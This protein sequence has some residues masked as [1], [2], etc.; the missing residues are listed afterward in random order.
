MNLRYAS[1][2]GL[3][4]A[5]AGIAILFY[6]QSL[7][8]TQIDPIMIQVFAVALMVWARLTFGM[9]S[10]HAAANPTEGGLVTS[11]PY[12]FVRHPIYAAVLYFVWAGIASHL[13]VISVLCGI[14]VFAGLFVRILA[15][16]QLVVKRYPEYTTYAQK[17]R[18]LIPYLF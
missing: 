1:I 18:R 8:A 5:V 2:A 7:L 17:T 10:F 4:L 13:S 11:G 12:H 15:E 9:R 16:E 3:L 6:E 14:G